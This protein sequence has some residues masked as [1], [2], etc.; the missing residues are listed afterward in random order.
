MRQ[1]LAEGTRGL[2]C[3]T[4]LSAP[5]V[6]ALATA[7]YA[8][9]VRYVSRGPTE[10][11]HDLA[12]AEVDTIRA[13]GLG[14]MVVQHVQSDKSWSPDGNKGLEWGSNAA[15][16]CVDMGIAPG[17][18]VWL[19]LE[20]V[21]ADTLV[22]DVIS[23]CRNWYQAVADAGFEPGVYCGWHTMLTPTELYQL[24]FTRYW[25]AYNLNADQYPIK[26]G[27]CMKQHSL[28]HGDIP[29]GVA[30]DTD[31]ADTDTVHVDAYGGLPSMD[32]GDGQA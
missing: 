5:M 25:A 32:V 8:F 31:N 29:D 16:A 19:D 12:Q 14:L 22:T 11:A 10:N 18:T 21:A 7:G 13:G 27:V 17:T 2:D 30:L 24:P 4:V 20:G 26:R 9:V 3:N 23:Y 15:A 1:L 6:A 28:K